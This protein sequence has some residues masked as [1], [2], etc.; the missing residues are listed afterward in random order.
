[1]SYT[2]PELKEK[3]TLFI[4]SDRYAGEVIEVIA[5]NKVVVR[6]LRATRTDNNGYG[7]EQE[8]SFES[9]ENGQTEIVVKSRNSNVWKIKGS[10][11]RVAFGFADQYYDPHF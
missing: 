4:G 3:C 5:K 9:N 8:Y 1:M 11:L 2:T 6:H 7:G 10:S